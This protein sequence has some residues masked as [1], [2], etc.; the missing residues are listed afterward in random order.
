MASLG[1]VITSIGLGVV[2]CVPSLVFSVI[3]MEGEEKP[4]WPAVLGFVL[5]VFP[6][7]LGLRVLA[8]ILVDCLNHILKI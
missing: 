7:G 8:K 5:S 6:G 3:G 2:A 4:L 1:A